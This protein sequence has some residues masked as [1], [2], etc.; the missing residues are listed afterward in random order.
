MDGGVMD[1]LVGGV[2]HALPGNGGEDCAYHVTMS[3]RT[4]ELAAAMAAVLVAILLSRRLKGGRQKGASE[5][6]KRPREYQDS[7]LHT[8]LLLFTTF[9]YGLQFGYKLSTRQVLFLLNP[10]H[11]ITVVCVYLLAAD[12]W[13]PD[14]VARA[15]LL[16]CLHCLL[17]PT[18]ALVFPVTNTLFLPLEA[19][20]YWVQHVIDL[21]VPLYL[22]SG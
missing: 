14:S 1:A 10:C 13:K 8:F 20:T 17:G 11:V 21:A 2:D 19:A 5:L 7:R 6:E 12:P 18:L 22:L 15:V 3:W 4:A 9:V 16:R